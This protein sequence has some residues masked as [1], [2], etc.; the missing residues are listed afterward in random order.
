MSNRRDFLKQL[1]LSAAAIALWTPVLSLSVKHHFI[2]PHTLGE[3]GLERLMA[4]EI[5][6]NF[7]V[8]RGLKLGAHAFRRNSIL[9]YDDTFY[10]VGAGSYPTSEV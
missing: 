2:V 1:G 3:E 5:G 10:M 4:L 8:I 7:D 9:N 6:T